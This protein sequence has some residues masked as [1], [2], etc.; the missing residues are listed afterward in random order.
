MRHFNKYYLIVLGLSIPP[1]ISIFST[2]QFPHVHDG[3]VHLARM[4]A[5]FKALQDFQIPVRWAGDLNYGYGM[6]LFNFIYHVP[7][8]FSALFIFLGFGLVFTF[9]I[10]LSL[11]FLLSG[12][13]M[14]AFAK[15]FFNPSATSDVASADGDKKALIVTI[16]YQFAPFRLVELLVRGSYGE[17]YAYTFFPLVLFGLVKIFQKR[18]TIF[19]IVTGVATALLIPVSYTHLTLP[20]TPYV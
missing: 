16:F 13:F 6:P 2:L 1:L 3:I 10:V 12:V 18:E 7:Y 5:Y 9:K 11:S 14:F 15:A 20:T 17:V 4:A 8:L 19:V